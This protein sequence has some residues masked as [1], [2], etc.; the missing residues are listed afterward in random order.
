MTFFHITFESDYKTSM[1]ISRV[2]ISKIMREVKFHNAFFPLL[3]RLLPL[4]PP[5][6]RYQHSHVGCQAPLPPFSRNLPA[7]CPV[8]ALYGA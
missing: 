2:I 1:H 7:L 6:S 5:I 3:K 4:Y 8:R